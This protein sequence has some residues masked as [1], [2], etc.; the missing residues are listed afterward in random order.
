MDVDYS[1]QGQKI[2]IA[3]DIPTQ[4]I[5]YSAIDVF[6]QPVYFSIEA[7][8][9]IRTSRQRKA[10]QR[11]ILNYLDRIPLILRDPTI[12][13]VDPDDFSQKPGSTTVKFL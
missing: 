8:Q 5:L 2:D 12:V 13:V 6:N 9:Y 10:W 4:T 7:E 3:D 11:Y 1:C